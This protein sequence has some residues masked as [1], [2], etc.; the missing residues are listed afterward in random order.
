M[1]KFK[2]ADPGEG[3]RPRRLTLL[4]WNLQSPINLGMILRLAETY[5]VSV[6]VAH[7]N[8]L[9]DNNE[10]MK[11]VGD[12]ACGA[13]QRVGFERMD[14][15][16]DPLTIMG[17]RRLIST[18]VEAGAIALPDFNFGPDD[19]IILGNEYDGVP[20]S[21]ERAAAARIRIPMGDVWTPKPPSLKP[22]DPTRVATVVRDGMPNLNVAMAAGIICYEWFCAPARR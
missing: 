15:S 22:I 1:T 12:F 6:T 16:M 20:A 19:M 4:L 5:R 8:A 21:V 13:L 18:T 11:T 3:G 14:G 9:L 7:G 17:H 2:E 10:K